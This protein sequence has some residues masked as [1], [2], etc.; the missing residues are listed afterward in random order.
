MLRACKRPHPHMMRVHDSRLAGFPQSEAVL[1]APFGMMCMNSSVVSPRI[2]S[3]VAPKVAC[4]FCGALLHEV[5]SVS[6]SLLLDSSSVG[7]TAAKAAFAP[8]SI[9]GTI[10]NGH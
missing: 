9:F 1:D 5:G 7:C 8:W 10:P 6:E 3:Q 2:S 4:T